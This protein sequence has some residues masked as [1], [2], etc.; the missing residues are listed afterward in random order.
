MDIAVSTLIARPRDEVFAYVSDY[1]NDPR[2]RAG[3]QE[4]TLNPRGQSQLGTTS[5]EVLRF[6]GMKT[7][8]DGEVTHY[9]PSQEIAFVGTMPDGTS[10]SNR[11]V[12][13][14]VAEH[15]NET[16]FTYELTVG[17]KGVMAAFTPVM[18]TMMRR[19][20]AA[21]LARLKHLLEAGALVR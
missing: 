18:Q 13:A 2:W 1:E 21:D 5:H 4:M 8:T 3:I 16:Q 12:V 7:T 11:R 10:V 9:E 6:F 20:C 19:L 15:R 14:T 17:L